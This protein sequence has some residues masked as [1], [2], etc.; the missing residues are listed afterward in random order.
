M[1]SRRSSSFYPFCGSAAAVRTFLVVL[2]QDELQ[3]WLMFIPPAVLKKK[4]RVESKQI[5]DYKSSFPRCCSVYVR[6]QM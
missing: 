2:C 6:W 4:K 5:V 3:T 1:S